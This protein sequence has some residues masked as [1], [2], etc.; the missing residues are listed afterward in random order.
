MRM[1]TP[2]LALCVALGCTPHGAQRDR[3]PGPEGESEETTLTQGPTAGSP[4]TPDWDGFVALAADACS[5]CHG[6][7]GSAETLPLPLAIQVDIDAGNELYVVPGDAEASLLW[8]VLADGGMPLGAAMDPVVI[9]PVRR[10]IDGGAGVPALPRDEDED[11]HLDDVDC[12][13]NDAAVHPDATE[14]CD[15]V[16]NNCDGATDD[17]TSA[18]ASTWYLDGDAD[19]WGLEQTSL[20]SCWAPTGWVADAGD[21]A[22]D[23]TPP[24]PPEDLC[25]R[26]AADRA[27]PRR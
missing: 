8:Q 18:D 10:W 14:V 16:D 21:S 27:D 13:D 24:A 20:V 1:D 25:P 22:T 7:E 2:I 9:D 5:G 19:G 17:P 23:P 11:G 6:P 4:Y 26:R 12:D 3:S 15:G